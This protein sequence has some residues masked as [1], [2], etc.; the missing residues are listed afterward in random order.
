MIEYDIPAHECE[1]LDVAYTPNWPR[2]IDDCVVDVTQNIFKLV[3]VERGEWDVAV[4]V[5]SLYTPLLEAE[6]I[7]SR[8]LSLVPTSDPHGGH[9]DDDAH[10][11]ELAE[12]VP[13][14]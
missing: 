8:L 14:K 10:D 2:Q 3:T 11:T 5:D 9:Q 13:A 7:F 1:N 6:L 4:L 12:L